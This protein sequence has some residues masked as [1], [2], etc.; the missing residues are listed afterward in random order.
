MRSESFQRK[1]PPKAAV[2]FCACLVF[3]L[4]AHSSQAANWYVSKNG[5]NANGESWSTAWNELSQINWSAINSG[6]T[7]YLDGGTDGM[8]YGA[9]N[10]GSGGTAENRITIAR[11]TENGHDGKVTFTGAIINHPYI[12]IDGIAKDKLEVFGAGG[13]TFRVQGNSTGFELK[14]IYLWGN[15]SGSFGVFIYVTAGSLTL[16]NVE[17]SGQSARE[18]QIK[19]YSNSDLLIEDSEFHGWHSIDGSHSDFL[20]GC[21][22]GASPSCA[23]GNITIRRSVFYDAPHD[24][25]MMGDSALGNVELS[26][27][28]FHG[29]ADAFKFVSAVSLKNHNNIFINCRELI[30]SATS[31]D[32]R[33]NIYIGQSS[34]GSPTNT[35]SDPQHSLWDVGALGFVAGNGNIQADPLFQ[36]RNSLLGPDGKPATPDDGFVLLS[37]SPAIN[38]GVD[39]GLVQ[40]IIK[41]SLVGAP[42]IGAYEYNGDTASD[43]VSPAQPTGLQIH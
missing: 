15:S 31:P 3:F 38:G 43:T 32:C 8:S 10:T 25:F 18:D 2:Y 22:S 21:N 36:N 17:I 34:W 14:N 7:V 28:I 13:Y 30:G 4:F 24:C 41:N 33:N 39:V 6:D 1:T 16:R 20:E 23:Q 40:D 35:C 37:G 12:T 29:V 26:Y 5:S 9:I 11:S 19:F 27:N 42:D